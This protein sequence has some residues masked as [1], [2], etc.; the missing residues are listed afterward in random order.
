MFGSSGCGKEKEEACPN[1]QQQ[2]CVVGY[3]PVKYNIFFS[4]T[5]VTCY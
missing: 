4:A 3:N 1:M 2:T 5:I